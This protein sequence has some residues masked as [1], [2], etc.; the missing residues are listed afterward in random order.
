[1][2]ESAPPPRAEQSPQASPSRQRALLIASVAGGAFLL[3][4]AAALIVFLGLRGTLFGDKTAPITPTQAVKPTPTVPI[5]PLPS[6]TCETIISSGEVELAVPLPVSLTVTSKVFPVAPLVPQEQSWAYPPGQSGS[7]AWL[8]GTIVNYVVGLEPTPENEALLAALRPGD[9]IVLRLSNRTELFFRF[10]ERREATVGEESVLRQ[11]KPRLTLIVGKGNDT[12]QVAAADYVA[13]TEPVEPPSSGAVAQP[14]QLVRLGD[15]QMTVVK[16]HVGQSEADLP[17]GT[18]YYLVEF[19]VENTGQTSL[20]PGGFSMTL[21]DGVGNS[22]LLSPAASA[23]GEHGPLSG[24]IAPGA[25]AKGTAGYIVPDPLAGPSLSWTFA[26]RPGSEIRASVQIPHESGA[27]S[28]VH[29]DV[30]ISDAFLNDARDTLIIEGEIRN[31]G[32]SQITVEAR[33]ISLSS[34]AGISELQMAAPP[35]PWAI[36]PGQSQVIELQ[37]VRPGASSVLLELLGYSFE[38]GGL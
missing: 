24:E 13:E 28:A 10:T 15:V 34:S 11:R 19:T 4:I 6:P 20:D 22:Y 9:E 36:Q 17:A 23:V 30:T 37:Y 14:G 8:C 16:G 32:A 38:I 29:A 5:S 35:L 27:P 25:T 18:M 31:S 3:L 26:P 12:W 33:D 7:A 2:T 1:M 21:N